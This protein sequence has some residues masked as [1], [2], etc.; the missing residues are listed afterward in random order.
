M[1]PNPALR[2]LGLSDN[3]R[4]VI[5]HA[6]DIG[7]C[8][9]SL[10]AYADMVAF[11]LLSSAATMVPCAWFPATAA[12]YRSRQPAL[13]IGVHLTLNSEWS[14]MRWGPIASRD[15]ATGLLDKEGYF[16]R[17]EEEFQSRADLAAVHRELQAQIEQALASG[18]DITHIDSHMLALF[19]PRFLPVYFDLARAYR[20]PAFML[21]A[22]E[23]R[24]RQMGYD[25][26]PAAVVAN[27]IQAAEADGLPL[28]DHVYFMSLDKHEDRL[29]EARQALEQI[30][31]G[32]TYFIVH[33]AHDT[34]E[35]RAMAP[36]WRSRVADC[37]LFTSEAWRGAVR[38]AGVHVIGYRPLRE[39][40]RTD[41]P[42]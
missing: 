7:C 40:M 10:S 25:A 1:P 19:H 21:R 33:P 2:K 41:N 31:A 36:D 17:T 3:D 16:Y 29:E 20:T 6:D 9:A 39:L 32:I 8:Q 22:D 13:D 12:F 5:F 11:G 42:L 23:A 27:L 30:P 35:L 26:E 24:L 14:G 18:L 28:L 4:V 37:E 38:E 15:P 34:P